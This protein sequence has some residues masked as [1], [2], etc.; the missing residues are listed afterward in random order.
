MLQPA[1]GTDDLA[2][3][4]ERE[5]NGKT[6][7]FDTVIPRDQWEDLFRVNSPEGRTMETQGVY[8]EAKDFWN[9]L[10][11][12]CA[13][14]MQEGIDADAANRHAKIIWSGLNQLEHQYRLF[15]QSRG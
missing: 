14:Q 15:Q 5:I 12:I 4:V 3:R 2:L 6:W 10:A 8:D 9:Y 1:Y 7:F 13:D 11:E